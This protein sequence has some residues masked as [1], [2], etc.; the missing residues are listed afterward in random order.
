MVKIFLSELYVAMTGHS[1]MRR[2]SMVMKDM[3]GVCLRQVQH[4]M[5]SYTGECK[6]GLSYL[7]LLSHV[8][9]SDTQ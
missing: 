4:M 6:P 7:S 3:V 2:N 8:S 5:G 1:A 9:A